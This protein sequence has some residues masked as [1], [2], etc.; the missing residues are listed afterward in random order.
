[1]SKDIMELVISFT[2]LQLGIKEE[3]VTLETEIP[4]ILSLSISIAI[5]INEAMMANV[6]KIYTV[7]EA[8]IQFE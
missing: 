8:I 2:A 1:M 7:E 5:E 4:D 3:A 6:K